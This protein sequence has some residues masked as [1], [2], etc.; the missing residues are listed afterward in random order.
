MARSPRKFAAQADQLAE[1]ITQLFV[2][3]IRKGITDGLRMA[4]QTTRHDSS[5]A[6]AHWMVGF[7]SQ[8]IYGRKYGKLSDLRRGKDPLVGS[9]GDKR[10]D[11]GMT[12][13]VNKAIVA[14]EV[15]TAIEKYARGQK[16]EL[17][18]YYY[19]AAASN[20]RYATNA[21]I[22]EAG[23]QAVAESVAS[24]NREISL[25][26]NIRRNRLKL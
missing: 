25:P 10:T 16:P 3:S 20:D 22:K 4:V 19:N 24:F 8:N 7:G 5:N 1:T 14:R 9:K 13:D 17:S 6:A 18:Y 12:A 15:E 26:G 21:K 11:R 2:A 23:K